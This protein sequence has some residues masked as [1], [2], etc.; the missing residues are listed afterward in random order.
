MK[1]D[2][3]FLSS[4]FVILTTFFFFLYPKT[5]QDIFYPLSTTKQFIKSTNIPIPTPTPQPVTLLAV[6]DV[7]LSRTEATKIK[8]Y[9]SDYPFLKMK[10]LLNS[11]YNNAMHLSVVKLPT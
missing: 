6:G 10:P 9:G 7:M 1:H 2:M 3:F 4:L 5:N 11:L 8:Q